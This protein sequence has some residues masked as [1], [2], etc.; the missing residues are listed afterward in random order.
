MKNNL[1]KKYKKNFFQSIFD[2]IKALFGK[3]EIE[4]ENTQ[5]RKSVLDKNIELKQ[6]FTE[7]IKAETN[8]KNPEYEKKEFMKNIEE[9]PELLEKF[10]NDRLEKI[11]QY[12]VEE[13][14]KKRKILNSL[15]S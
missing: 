10:S 7:E 8:Y 14:N 13:N 15:N 1:P 2:K 6:N 12:Y 9:N 3:K 4:Q 11:L 5:T